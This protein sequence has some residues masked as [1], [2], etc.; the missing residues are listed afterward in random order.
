MEKKLLAK[1]NERYSDY[2]VRGTD[3]DE[4]K[5][6]QINSSTS[7]DVHFRITIADGGYTT[8]NIYPYGGFGYL[9]TGH[10]DRREVTKEVDNDRGLVDYLDQYLKLDEKNKI[11]T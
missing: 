3:M 5:E 6:V 7:I 9:V 4:I 1:L 10:L 8:I 11:R 2:M